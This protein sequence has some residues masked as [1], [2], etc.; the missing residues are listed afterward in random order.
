LN[1][2]VMGRSGLFEEKIA[3]PMGVWASVY[4]SC[5]VGPAGSGIQLRLSALVVL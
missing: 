3:G 1:W 5:F 4:E 2:A